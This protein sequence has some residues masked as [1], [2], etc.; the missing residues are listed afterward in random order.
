[1]G[2]CY[3]YTESLAD[4]EDVLQEGFIRVFTSLDQFRFEGSFEGWIRRIMVHTALNYL[5]KNKS[6]KK[7]LELEEEY[8]PVVKEKALSGLY[9]DEVLQVLE[10]L[11]VGYRTIINL[12]A[13][14]GYSHKEIGEMLHIS[15]GTSRS[16]YSRGKK[17]LSEKINERE[18]VEVTKS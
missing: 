1:M 18:H 16:Q 14:E 15:E 9:K 7:E 6:F 2:V 10:S 4:A 13:I 11:P 8:H 17:L 12:Y 5:K 3:R